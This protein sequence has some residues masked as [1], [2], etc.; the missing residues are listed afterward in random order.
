MRLLG[1]FIP[2]EFESIREIRVKDSCGP[3]FTFQPIN[4][5]TFLAPLIR[6]SKF[7]RHQKINTNKIEKRT[8]SV[9]FWTDF[10]P[11]SKLDR[12]KRVKLVK[13]R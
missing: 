12:K 8:D 1:E 10:P 7:S 5:S 3:Y 9:Q 4:S 13:K 2:P 6:V 11:S